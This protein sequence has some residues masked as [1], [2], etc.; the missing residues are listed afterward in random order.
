MK[1]FREMTD[2][3]TSPKTFKEMRMETVRTSLKRFFEDPNVET[4]RLDVDLSQSQ[5]DDLMSD[6]FTMVMKERKRGSVTLML[7][8]EQEPT[9]EKKTKR[10]LK[11]VNNYDKHG[12]FC[13]DPP[14]TESPTTSHP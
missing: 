9:T 11:K 6:F 5:K 8:R 13:P 10:K 7:V 2:V 12:N 4:I 3:I 14:S 1:P